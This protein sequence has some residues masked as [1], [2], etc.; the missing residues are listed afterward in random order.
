MAKYI[1]IA[2]S[3]GNTYAHKKCL[4]KGQTEEQS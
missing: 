2:V 3:F 4:D 1:V